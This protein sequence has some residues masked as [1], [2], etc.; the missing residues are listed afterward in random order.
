MRPIRF[1]V[2]S[3]TKPLQQSIVATLS[4]LAS[5]LGNCSPSTVYR[6]LKQ[7]DYIVSYSHRGKYYALLECA[8]FD[9]NGLWFYK[10]IRFSR[11]G[12][13]RNC[14]QAL[15]E[16]S[17]LGYRPSELD[18]LLR[19]RTID[20]L[21]D[22][23][24]EQQ[25]TRIRLEGRSI[26]CAVDSVKQAQQMD[27]RRI[28]QQG[29]LPPFMETDS[30]PSAA[31]ALF[32]SILNE[33]HRRRFAGLLSLCLGH[34]GD[35]RVSRILGLNRKTIQRGRRELNSGEVDPNRIRKPGGGRPSIQKNPR[36]KRAPPRDGQTGDSRDS[37]GRRI[38]D[39]PLPVDLVQSVLAGSWNQNRSNDRR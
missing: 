6:K 32:F 15:V 25:L 35:Q 12:T 7:L 29:A 16:T 24:R 34:G 17:P 1:P 4:E 28:Q 19:V 30:L 14:V 13:L 22:L 8:D 38:L 18:A 3:L 10:N 2:N 33:K 20:T 26:Y 23:V 36:H 21:A 37:H 9:S 5:A 39:S 31:M 27:A 11:H